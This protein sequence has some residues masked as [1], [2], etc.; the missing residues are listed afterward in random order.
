MIAH[1]F[2]RSVWEDRDW[3]YGSRQPRRVGEAVSALAATSVAR[4]QR[5]VPLFGST[6]PI[7]LNPSH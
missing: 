5:K 6:A 1:P 2:H 3:S 7:A 4:Q